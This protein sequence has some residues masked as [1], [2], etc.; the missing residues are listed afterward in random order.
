[1][2]GVTDEELRSLFKKSDAKIDGLVATLRDEM[3]TQGAQLRIELRG[4][5]R[6][7]GEQLRSEMGKNVREFRAEIR[8]QGDQLR[9]ETRTIAEA[10]RTQGEELRRHFDVVAERFDA[11][12]DLL[13]EG[14]LNLD[15]KMDHNDAAIREEMQHGFADTH[16]LIKY[17]FNL[18]RGAS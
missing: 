4:E 3:R 16:A 18:S 13:A 17:A 1:M 11:K 6:L 7:Q 9:G 15:E 2:P 12:Y 14:I 10:L 5:M 8:M